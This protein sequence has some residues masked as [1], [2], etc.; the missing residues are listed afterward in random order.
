MND[1]LPTLAYLEVNGEKYTDVVS[2]EEGLSL[3]SLPSV[4]L[5]F[6]AKK[7]SQY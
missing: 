1:I 2:Y 5:K 7:K 4:E 6:L 3:S